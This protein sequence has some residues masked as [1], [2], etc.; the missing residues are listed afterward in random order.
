MSFGPVCPC[1]AANSIILATFYPTPGMLQI[2]ASIPVH[3]VLILTYESAA[4]HFQ[5]GPAPAT[6]GVVFAV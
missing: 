5:K 6:G 1:L 4:D 3:P 2:I